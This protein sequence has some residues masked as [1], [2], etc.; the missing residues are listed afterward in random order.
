VIAVRFILF[1][2]LALRFLRFAFAPAL[3]DLF[4]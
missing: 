2:L 4:F 1:G 3:N